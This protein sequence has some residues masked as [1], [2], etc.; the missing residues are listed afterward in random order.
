MPL[1]LYIEEEIN[2]MLTLLNNASDG[3]LVFALYNTVANRQELVRK[4]K[5][6]L[7]IP[8]EELYV[9]PDE[10][11]PVNLLKTLQPSRRAA[12]AFY[13]IEQGFPDALGYINYQREVFWKY[14]YGFIF[15]VTEYGRNEIAVK[16]PDFWSRRS[17]VF[18]FRVKESGR[19]G[20][21]RE[22]LVGEPIYYE[23]K[24]ELLKKLTLYKSLLVEY[25]KEEEPNKENIADLMGKIAKIHYL[26]ADY[27]LA[28][29]WFRKALPLYQ[30]LK[31]QSRLATTYNNIGGIYHAQGDYPEALGWYEKSLKI[32]EE[33]GDRAG[34]A[35]TYNNIGGIYQAQGDYPE[36]LKWFQK[37]LRIR[38]EIGD[39][40]GL[41]TTYNNI[42]GIYQ[43]QGNYQEALGW[44]QKSKNILERIGNKHHLAIVLKNIG[45]LFQRM[46]QKEEAKKHLQE[47]QRLFKELGLE[48]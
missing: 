33:I 44:Y 16:A 46:G 30:E 5:E 9:T 10:K 26:T 40:A 42:G 7:K 6:K 14:S 22:R 8:F 18:D 37:S 23:N 47:S 41:A 20:E 31:S 25:Q 17:G 35:T 28:L 2:R 39:R 13:N 21:M 43:A 27:A 34:L 15:W 38:E 12:V 48:K 1:D 11:N 45:L 29:E 4:L 32:R 3:C 36:A 19:I 24:D